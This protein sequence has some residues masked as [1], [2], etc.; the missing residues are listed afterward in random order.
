MPHYTLSQAV[1][2]LGVNHDTARRQAGASARHGAWTE[3]RRYMGRVLLAKA[4]LH[5]TEKK[6][7]KL[8]CPP[9]SPHSL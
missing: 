8:S 5:S 7:K 6:P 3:A 1:R 2:L 9:N 4:R